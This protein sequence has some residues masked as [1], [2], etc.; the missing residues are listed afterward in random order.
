MGPNDAH[1]D[2]TVRGRC[3]YENGEK[4]GQNCAF[5]TDSSMSRT[6]LIKAGIKAWFDEASYN[7]YFCV[8]LYILRATVCSRS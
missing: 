6:Q 8:Y 3:F 2:N 7:A 5:R 1:D 4:L